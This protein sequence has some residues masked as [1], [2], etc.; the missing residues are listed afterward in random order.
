MLGLDPHDKFG[1]KHP[2]ASSLAVSDIYL[3]Q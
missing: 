2:Q 1:N 3:V